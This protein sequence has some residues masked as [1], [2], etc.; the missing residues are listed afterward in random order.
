MAATFEV[1]HQSGETINNVAGDQH[2]HLDHARRRTAKVLSLLGFVLSLG[3]LAG[4]VAVAVLAGRDAYD[5]Y[6]AGTLAPPYPSYVPSAWPLAAG[7]LAAGFVLGR[8]G[9]HLSR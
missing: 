4:L 2:L 7:A 9:R 6:L 1:D 8:V 5:A 3:G